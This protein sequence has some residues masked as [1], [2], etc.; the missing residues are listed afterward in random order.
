MKSRFMVIPAILI[1]LLNFS[2]EDLLEKPVGSDVTIDT[3]FNSEVNAL[4][5]LGTVYESCAING[6][7]GWKDGGCSDALMMAICDEGDLQAPGTG[8]HLFNTGEWGPTTDWHGRPLE[9]SLPRCYK[10]IRNAN[11]LIENIDRVE[12]L[13]PEKIACMKAEAI[14]FRALMHFDAMQRYGG[15]PIVDHVL[16]EGELK[17]P[18]N[19]FDETV[20]FIVKSCDE[21][22]NFLPDEWESNYRGRITKGAPLALKSRTLLYAASPLFNTAE[23]YVATGE[24][25]LELIC[26]GNEDVSRWQV[27]ADASKAVIDWAENESGWCTLQTS[28]GS[29]FENYNSAT[30]WVND[31]EIILNDRSHQTWAT[32]MDSYGNQVRYYTNSIYGSWKRSHGVSFNITQYFYKDDGENQIWDEEGTYVEFQQ[33][34]SEMEPRFQ[35]SVCWSGPQ[36]LWNGALGH[37]IEAWWTSDG[38]SEIVPG[39]KRMVASLYACPTGVGHLAKFLRNMNDQQAPMHWIVFRLA[40]FYLN[41]AEAL[42]EVSP[43]DQQAFDAINKVRNRAELPE[44]TSASPDCNTQD[45]FRQVIR[46]ERAVELFAEEHRPFDVRRWKIAGNE[47]VMK[48]GLYTLKLIQQTPGTAPDPASVIYRKQKVEDRIWDDK[49]YLYPFPQDEVNLGYL[50]QN[51]GW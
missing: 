38:S 7:P 44:L 8:A 23:S 46:R 39:P 35:V 15:I 14:F 32:W 4:K 11:L 41:Y 9:F 30:Y 1:V 16:G 21:A 17:I 34:M 5:F 13:D 20:S 19:T 10:G 33:K 48:G 18:R 31:P 28:L 45:G 37:P 40:E 36:S 24:I 25:P 42:N 43:L 3:V 27:A 51:P 49:M 47:G 2:C 12:D 29:T 50:V 6:F 26:Y 22:V